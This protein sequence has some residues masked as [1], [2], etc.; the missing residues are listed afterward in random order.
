MTSVFMLTTDPGRLWKMYMQLVE[1][2]WA[3]RIEK[4]ELAIRPIWHHKPDRVQAHILVC[5]LAYVLWKTLAQWMKV[6]GLGAAPRTLVE[7]FAKIKSGDVVLPTVTRD[8]RPGK[9][10]RVRCVTSPDAAQKVLLHR[11]DLTLPHRLRYLEEVSQ[12]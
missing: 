5:F 11:R 1:A 6:S 9:T 4:D 3:F 12:V 7:E 8:G 10:V 2:E